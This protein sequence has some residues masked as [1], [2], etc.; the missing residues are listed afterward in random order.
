MFRLLKSTGILGL[1]LTLTA[2]SAVARVQVTQIGLS[3]QIL[4]NI[5]HAYQSDL[6][7]ID[8]NNPN[9]IQILALADQASAGRNMTSRVEIYDGQTWVA[10]AGN[11]QVLSQTLR[12]GQNLYNANDINAAGLTL[13]YNS[14][15][16]PDFNKLS[17]GGILP[18]ANFR[19][20]VRPVEPT[21]GDPYMMQLSLFT[22]RSALNQPPIPIY[23]KGVAVN[24]PLPLF[25][26]TSVPKAAA[27]EVMVGPN[28]DT[29][30]NTFWR[31]GRIAFTQTMYPAD[32]RSLENGQ[33]YYWQVKALDGLGNP[34]GGVDGRSQPADFT[35]NSSARATTA[36]SP[37]DVETA[38]KA[39]IRDQTIFAPVSGYRAAAV[40]TTADD[41]TGLLQQLRDGSATVTSARVE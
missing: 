35:I 13:E 24:T 5:Y 40:E 15:Y 37:A 27:Y 16:T 32:A 38:L 39:A 10:R 41:L 30:V 25:S 28:Q 18:A 19:I 29:N 17:S 7:T 11:F 22:P 4:L 6:N 36:I 20:V 34:V 23:P 31:S 1:L 3:P 9:I 26:W 8:W 12:A 21:P 2:G 14:N 33:R